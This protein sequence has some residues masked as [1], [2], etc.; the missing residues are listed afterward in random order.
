MIRCNGIIKDVRIFRSYIK[1]KNEADIQEGEYVFNQTQSL[2]EIIESLKS[3]KI[4][5]EPMYTVT[6]PEGKTV[7]Q[8][9]EIFANHLSFTK[10]EFLDIDRKSTR[11][12]SSHVAIS[13]AVFGVIK[14][15]IRRECQQPDST[16]VS[17]VTRGAES[18]FSANV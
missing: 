15:R 11:L 5:A 17:P 6:N 1:F 7:E 13:Y 12:N 3:G 14:K 18:A 9:D 16:D 4:L 2:D 10:D 8:I